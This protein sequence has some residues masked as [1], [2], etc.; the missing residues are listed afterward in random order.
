MRRPSLLHVALDHKEDISRMSKNKPYTQGLKNGPS[1]H[2]KSWN[3]CYMN[4]I[5]QS[6]VPLLEAWARA[7]IKIL[8]K[9]KYAKTKIAISP[10]A[11]EFAFFLLSMIENDHALDPREILKVLNGKEH[12]FKVG[13]Q[14]DALS[15]FIFL[16]SQAQEPVLSSYFNINLRK[17]IQCTTC[18]HILYRDEK[19]DSERLQKQE[20]CLFLDLSMA[21]QHTTLSFLLKSFYQPEEVEYKCTYNGEYACTGGKKG[22]ALI[23]SRLILP[24]Q[25]IV[26]VLTRPTLDLKKY[27]NAV[28]I[29]E[30]QEFTCYHSNPNVPAV[31]VLKEL[32][33]A[34]V[35]SGKHSTRGHYIAFV[36][37]PITGKWWKYDDDEVTTSSFSELQGN[38]RSICLLFYN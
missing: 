32:H 9:K 10:T 1:A 14:Y 23:Q 15:F 36:K 26:V 34:V 13:K 21:P 4:A 29:E 19:L 8:S 27:S 7:L 6:L 31:K 38:N 2:S 11:Y 30:T 22:T 24:L 12:T 17:A 3:M 25:G 33:S 5:L 20:K 28:H 35:H 37:H 16:L 18:A